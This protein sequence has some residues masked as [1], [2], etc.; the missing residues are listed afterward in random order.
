MTDPAQRVLQLLALMQSRASWSGPELAE[1]LQVTARTLRRDIARLRELGYPVQA[2]RG[3]DGGYRLGAGGRLPPLM[4][5]D[6]EAIALVACLRMGALSDQDAVGEAA[7]RALAKLDQ[8]LPPQL[9]AVA[10]ALDEA[11]QAIPRVRPQIDLAA[12]SVLAGAHRDR[13]TLRFDYTKPGAEPEPRDVEPGRLMTQGE[14]WYLHG[15]D[16]ARDDWR[17]FRVDRISRLRATTLPFVPRTPPPLDAQRPVAER[18]PC[19]VQVRFATSAESLAQCVPAM[20]RERVEALPGG[21]RCRIGAASW[22]ELALHLL[23][24]SRELRTR[25]ELADDAGAAPLR[26]A[27]ERLAS[28][29]RAV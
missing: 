22:D 24:I 6:D 23:R 26:A 12:L 5:A 25:L 17:L 7:L 15:Y 13:R 27:L 3:A 9:R 28:E 8:V 19:V 16:R 10:A 21:C 29:A 18:W 2:Q 11:T 14:R 1:R 4:L 20:H